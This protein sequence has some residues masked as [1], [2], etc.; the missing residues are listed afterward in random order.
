MMAQKLVDPLV[1]LEPLQQRSP[2]MQAAQVGTRTSSGCVA[3]AGFLACA[4]AS[5]Q[6]PGE[7]WT[8][9]VGRPE[10]LKVHHV[11]GAG[12]QHH[13]A[14]S[15]ADKRA[16]SCDEGNLGARRGVPGMGVKAKRYG[17][18]EPRDH[19]QPWQCVDLP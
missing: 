3:P 15:N 11:N 13:V 5:Q 4:C 17:K 12:P 14:Y 19:V 6:G 18:A 9:P 7:A 10:H 2:R 16:D 1:A 8:P